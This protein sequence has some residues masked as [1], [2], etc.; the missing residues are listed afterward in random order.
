MSIVALQKVTILGPVEDKSQIIDDLQGLGCLHLCSLNP[1]E[2][3]TPAKESLSEETREAWRFLVD[4]PRKR[5]QVDKSNRYDPVEMQ[6]SALEIRERLNDLGDRRDFLSRRIENVRVWGDF[7]FSPSMEMD[8]YHLWF[9]LVP[10]VQMS[11]VEATGLQYEI[12]HSDNL[13]VYVVVISKDEPVGMPV[14]RVAIGAKSLSQLENELEEIEL[15]I[16]D[17]QAQREELTRGLKIYERNMNRLSDMTACSKAGRLTLD[18]SPLFAIQAWA[19]KDHASSLREYADDRGLGIIIEDPS[20]ED[21]PPTLL[22]NSDRL[23]VGEDLVG[24]YMMPGYRLWDPSVVVLFSFTLFF[25]MIISDAG[26]GALMAIGFLLMRRKLNASET[27]KRMGV[28]FAMLSGATIL[29]GILVGSYFG[30]AP[31]ESSFLSN[32]NLL[33]MNNMGLMMAL[34]I[35]VGAAH[36]ILANAMDA[37]RQR[38]SAAA[39]APVGWIVV[40]VSALAWWR[41]AEGIGPVGLGVGL[42][43]VFIFSGAGV[44]A[45][46]GRRIASGLMSLAKVTNA[47]GDILSYLRLF[48]LGLASASLAIAF[49]DLA[50]DARDGIPGIGF[51]VALIVILVGHTLNFVLA[52]V[53]GFVHGLR[54][55]LIEFFNWSVTEEGRP[56]RAF[57]KKESGA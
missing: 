26:Y 12:V 18:S 27:G 35:F 57:H 50:R 44:D 48:A 1:D 41:G 19:P 2:A 29:W 56:F 36:V 49:N 40:I 17:L 45:G 16:D 55:N 13:N 4:C 23:K 34:S 11:E 22:E 32:L 8:G 30:V 39:L 3:L 38:E 42:L 37:W 6:S 25:A 7:E 51:L 20:E 5:F 54:L 31:S 53:S 47:F 15:E 14:E 33:D 10:H 21:D 24:F 9:F 46:F 43:M 52:I 28:L